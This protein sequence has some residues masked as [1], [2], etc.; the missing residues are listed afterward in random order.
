MQAGEASWKGA[1][2]IMSDASFITT[3]QNL[4]AE[5]IPAK[6]VNAI[7]GAFY[8]VSHLFCCRGQ[9]GRFFV[10]HSQRRRFIDHDEV[11]LAKDFSL[12]LII[13]LRGF[14][15]FKEIGVPSV[16]FLRL[17]ETRIGEVMLGELG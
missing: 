11:P 6:N 15:C 7:K 5:A 14:G 8:E 12:K 3:L 9:R 1:R 17:W 4:D 2:G 10:L 16:F 13:S